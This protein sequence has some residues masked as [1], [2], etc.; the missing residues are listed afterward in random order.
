MIGLFAG[1]PATTV[2]WRALLVMLACW[3]IGR[4][5]GA[6]AQRAI[7]DH[8]KRYKQEHP[9]PGEDD[10]A[11]DAATTAGREAEGPVVSST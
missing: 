6:V 5:V 1:N 3:A 7:D 4:V 8:L 9:I 11:D 2:I 10:E